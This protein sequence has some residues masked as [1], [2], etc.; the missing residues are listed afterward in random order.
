VLITA[1]YFRHGCTQA[2]LGL[3]ALDSTLRKACC[4]EVGSKAPPYLPA[5]L[6]R[7]FF[8]AQRTKIE[9]IWDTTKIVGEP[10]KCLLLVM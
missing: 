2:V 9:P 4:T 10:L 7:D 8:A 5:N 6:S 3:A 1:Y